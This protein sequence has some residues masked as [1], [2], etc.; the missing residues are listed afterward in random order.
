MNTIG[1]AAAA[2]IALVPAPKEQ[3]WREGTC[4]YVEA[5]VRYVRDAALPPEGYRLEV[6]T[7]SITVASADDAGAFYA[8]KTLKQLATGDGGRAAARPSQ[9]FGVLPV[10][11]KRN[12]YGRQLGSFT[13]VGTWDGQPKTPMTF[14]RAPAIT[15]LLSPDVEVLSA[16]DGAPTAVRWRTITACTWHPEL[17]H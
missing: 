5:D 3:V 14:I 10:T 8:R 12:A 2:A 9:W 1:I 6:T 15:A 11:V 16:F 4:A 7:D 17:T 13:T